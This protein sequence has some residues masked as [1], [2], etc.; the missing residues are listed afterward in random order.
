[1]KLLRVLSVMRIYSSWFLASKLWI[2]NQLIIPFSMYIIFALVIGKGFEIYALI[3]ATVTLSWNAGANAVS[4]QLFFHKHYYRIK[5][6]FVVSPLHPL[7]YAL[8]CGIGAL[9][10]A[11]LPAIP[12]FVMM[13]IYV[14]ELI[15]HA[16]T[17]FILSW[18][19]GT[20]FGFWLGNFARDP[21]K[22]SAIANIL[23][24]LLIMLPPVYYPVS[25]LPKW[26]TYPPYW[27]PPPHYLIY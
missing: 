1:M 20:L 26:A 16:F 13:A 15:V 8:G 17:V 22:L 3:G 6:I 9:L 18:F 21:A 27:C 14:G 7:E 5:D 23:Y 2:V 10:N 24:N 19:L 4:Q 12:V 25:V 11:A